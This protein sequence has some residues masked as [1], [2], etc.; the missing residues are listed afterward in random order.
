M[1]KK[2]FRSIDIAR[3]IAM[4]SIVLGHLGNPTINRVVFTYHLPIFFLITGYFFKPEDGYREFLSKKW[5][6][7]LVPYFFT[8]CL[9]CLFCVLYSIY[10][11]QNWLMELGSYAY[12]SLYGA[13]DSYV[14]P[15]YIKAIGAIWFLWATFWGELFLKKL[16]TL[17]TWIR[18]IIVAFILVLCCFSWR[19]IWLPL[20][21][22]AGGVALF[23]MYLGYVLKQEMPKIKE[24]LTTKRK[25]LLVVFCFAMWGLMIYQFE[26]FWLVHC[27]IGNGLLDI[28]GSLCGCYLLII[29]SGFLDR[30][31]KLISKVCA[32]Y[33]KYSLLFLSI[34]LLEMEWFPYELVQ[35]LLM[36]KL[37]VSNIGWFAVKVLMKLTIISVSM[38]IGCRIPVVRKIYGYKSLGDVRGHERRT[39]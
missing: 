2:R 23:Y 11:G 31:T 18:W 5:R 25:V 3:G 17:K 13:G 29:A 37:G 10:S 35:S 1:E 6:Q 24:A 19:I 28:L 21:I 9:M 22:Q 38:L 34:H 26:A 12:A 27:E 15:F 32:F 36:D 8:C 39:S 16:L 7:L 4:V 20:S 30:K 33:G 14:E